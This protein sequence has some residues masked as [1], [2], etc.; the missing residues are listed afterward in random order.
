MKKIVI[1]LGLPGSGKTTLAKTKYSNYKLIDDITINY[2]INYYDPNDKIVITCPIA[3]TKSKKEILRKLKL[4]F[5]KSYIT[6]IVYEN[7]YEQCIKNIESRN[8]G[9][10]ISYKTLQFLSKRYNP[11]E[12]SRK[13]LNV[14]NKQL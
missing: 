14:Y 8:D 1:I 5:G 4:W 10:N 7:N 13:I 12:F 3:G 2:N 6:F 11:Y 9:R